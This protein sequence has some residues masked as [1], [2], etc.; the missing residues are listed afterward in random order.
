MKNLPSNRASRLSRARSSVARSKSATSSTERDYQAPA[1]A[2]RL[3]RASAAVTSEE[4]RRTV[5]ALDVQY[6]EA[7]KRNDA[8]TMGRIMHDDFVLVLGNG[9]TFGRADL[10]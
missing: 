10:L 8:A 9:K 2:A 4:G 3:F 1:S 6:Q 5:A 7:V